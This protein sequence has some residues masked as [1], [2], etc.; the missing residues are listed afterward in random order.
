MIRVTHLINF[1][2]IWYDKGEVWQWQDYLKGH[3]II[4][5]QSD[6]I[7]LKVLKIVRIMLNVLKLIE[8]NT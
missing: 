1:I 6:T 3:L 4:H 2:L 8:N 5:N 7:M